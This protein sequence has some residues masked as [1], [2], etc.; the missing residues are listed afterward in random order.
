[1]EGTCVTL[2]Q[3]QVVS[4]PTSQ[5]RKLRVR[6]VSHCGR[7]GQLETSCGGY[8]VSAG[9]RASNRHREVSDDKARWHPATSSK[10]E[11]SRRLGVTSLRYTESLGSPEKLYP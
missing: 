5:I 2:R 3:V 7:Q 6:K 4:V 8:S 1:M 9:E 11:A 10:I